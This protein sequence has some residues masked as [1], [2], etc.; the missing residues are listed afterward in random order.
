[1]AKPRVRRAKQVSVIRKYVSELL[2]LHK[3]K[4]APVDVI[5]LA[6]K[7]GA[8][9]KLS[10]FDGELAGMLIRGN[11]K[12]IIGVNSLHHINRQRFTVAHE[13]GHLLMHQ[14]DVH[15]DKSFTVQRRDGVSSL[16]VDPD[17]IEANRFA[18]ELL[19]PYGLIA[20]DLITRDIDIENAEELME[21][22]KKYQVS[23]QAITFRVTA[24]M[25]EQF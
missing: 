9:V 14:G 19:M 2:K 18:A 15:I 20:A 6:Q 25:E 4:E 24:I 16:A 12:K 7:L 5:R 3:V 11:G 8:Q 10:P 13:I 23:L 22:A 17:E 1:M 21:L